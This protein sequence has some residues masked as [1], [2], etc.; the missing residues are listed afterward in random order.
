MQGYVNIINSNNEVVSVMDEKYFKKVDV[1]S[2]Y[3]TD[4]FKKRY[5]KFTS[6]KTILSNLLKGKE[7]ILR[8]I[9]G[10]KLIKDNNN[11]FN[12]AREIKILQIN[13]KLKAKKFLMEQNLYDIEYNIKILKNALSKH[14]NGLKC[15]LVNIKRCM[16]FEKKCKHCGFISEKNLFFTEEFKSII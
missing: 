13:D 2:I 7:I 12:M 5:R 3:V 11:E 9:S 15:I 4:L 14:G 8:M 1:E 10:I 6:C 16:C